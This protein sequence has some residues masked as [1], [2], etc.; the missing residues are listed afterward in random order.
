M[1]KTLQNPTFRY[2]FVAQVVAL[3]G[4]GLAT[5][6]LGLLAWQLAGDDAGAVLGTALAIKMVAYV[7]LAPVA[8]AIAERLPRRAFLVVLDLIRAG[9]IAW[10]D[11]TVGADR[12]WLFTDANTH[13]ADHQPFGAPSGSRR[14]LCRAICLVPCLLADH[15]SPCWL[16]RGKGR[17]FHGGTGSCRGWRG[18]SAGGA[19]T[20]ACRRSDNHAARPT[21]TQAQI[22]VLLHQHGG[23]GFCPFWRIWLAVQIK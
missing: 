14:G 22:R 12:I 10:A 21:V 13:R 3:L 9:V 5:V 23:P 4:T 8:A 6:A 18:R 7:T 20:V 16:D 17:S 19:A 2:L 11:G 1:L 15:L